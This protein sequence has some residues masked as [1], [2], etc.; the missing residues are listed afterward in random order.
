[1]QHLGSVPDDAFVLDL[2][3]DH[4][5]R[6]VHQEQQRH[7]ERIADLH[8]VRGLVGAVDV[9]D[10]AEVLGIVGNDSNRIAADARKAGDDVFR[11]ARLDVE[12]LAVVH[13]R[14]DE[15]VHVIRLAR[16][17]RQ[18][19]EQGVVFAV[20][21]IVTGNHR[22]LFPT[23]RRHVRQ[24]V[25]DRL[26]AG[27]FVGN[28]DI[29]DAGSFTVDAGAAQVLLADVLASDCFDQSRSAER[30]RALVFNHGHKVS[31][32]GNVS[33]SCCPWTHHSGDQWHHAGHDDF[34]AEQ[35]PRACK[36]GDLIATA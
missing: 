31:Q 7:V 13:H 3:A 2:A 32:A 33:R 9:E 18:Q 19:I 10:A 34:L 24:I 5:A 14:A 30:H 27:V 35:M 15:L 16:A 26:D 11:P 20:D 22:R 8:K 23:V 29:A 4:K 12:H 36:Q 28:L 21:R 6:H 1:M 17:R 25:F